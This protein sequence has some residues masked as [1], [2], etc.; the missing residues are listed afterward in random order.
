[1]S[2][3]LASLTEKAKSIS[4]VF[5][6]KNTQRIKMKNTLKEYI[7]QLTLFNEGVTSV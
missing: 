7:Y 2:D 3:R 1:M 5:D 6:K 4:T